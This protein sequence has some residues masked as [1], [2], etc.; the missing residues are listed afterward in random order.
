[1]APAV[2]TLLFTDV[3]DSTRVVERLGDARAAE[4]WA[5][6]DRRGRALLVRHRGREIDRTDGFFLLFDEPA[7]AARYALGY[8]AALADLGLSARVGIHVGAVTLREN[9]PEDIA[10]GAKP[11]ETEGLAKPLAARIMA[12][13]GGGQTL[14]SAAAREALADSLPDGTAIEWHGHYRL[15]GIEEPIGDLRAGHAGRLSVLAA[16]GRRQGLPRDP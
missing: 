9:T 12:L 7:D 1:M 8:H 16:C 5:A 3:V 15:K 4:I 2:R 10:Q 14:L 13:A 6:H 11:I